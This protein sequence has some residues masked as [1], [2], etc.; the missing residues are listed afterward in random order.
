MYHRGCWA[1]QSY[2]INQVQKN[3]LAYQFELNKI[4]L[5]THTYI[6]CKTKVKIYSMVCVFPLFFPTSYNKLLFPRSPSNSTTRPPP[7]RLRRGWYEASEAND[8]EVLVNTLPE[9]STARPADS[10][11]IPGWLG[12]WS[13]PLNFWGPRPNFSGVELM[14]VSGRVS[15][16]PLGRMMIPTFWSHLFF[17]CC[18]LGPMSL[19]LLLGPLDAEDPILQAF[20]VG[21]MVGKD[22]FFGKMCESMPCCF[23]CYL[24]FIYLVYNIPP[25]WLCLSISLVWCTVYIFKS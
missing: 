25:S 22:S 2:P 4:D 8:G 10:P 12:R 18:G 19:T 6:S 16:G 15:A 24:F 14:W 21:D 17:C 1:W 9:T 3:A 23:L 7:P 13:L 11:W 5:Y 20:F